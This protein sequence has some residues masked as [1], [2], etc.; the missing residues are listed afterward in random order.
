MKSWKLKFLE[1]SVL[2]QETDISNS[3]TVLSKCIELAYKDMMTAG[4]FYSTLFKSTKEE[5]CSETKQII[6]GNGFVFSRNLICEVSLLFSDNEVIGADNKYATRYGLA[7]KL[8]NMIFKY[9]YVF[10]DCIFT[11]HEILDFSNCDCPLDSIILNTAD[12]HNFVWSKAT[13]EQYENCQKEILSLLKTQSLDSELAKIGNL[14]FD[15]LN[16]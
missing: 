9:L 15:F 8:V 16:W 11:E 12:V 7:Q 10:S 6:A 5:I 4:R 13:P 3:E 2:G 14:A 1:K